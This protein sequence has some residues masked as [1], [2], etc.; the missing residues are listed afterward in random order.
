MADREQEQAGSAK[1]TCA[2]FCNCCPRGFREA[3]QTITTRTGPACTARPVIKAE[4]QYP[5]SISCTPGDGREP[6]F[7]AVFAG[8]RS[9]LPRSPRIGQAP[10]AFVERAGR[11]DREKLAA[12]RGPS[13][14]VPVPRPPAATAPQGETAPARW[15]PR[16]RRTPIGVIDLQAR[17]RPISKQKHGQDQRT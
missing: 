10:P 7:L 5:T 13:A 11:P 4:T 16:G 12:K 6:P 15:L 14:E 8:L 3:E 9:L 1:L 2:G 17:C